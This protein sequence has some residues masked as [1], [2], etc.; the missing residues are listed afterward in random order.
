MD[1]QQNYFAFLGLPESY[2]IDLKALAARSHELQKT[3]HPDRFAHLSEREKRLSVQ[4][5]AYLNEAVTTLKLPLGRAQYLLHLQGIDT[6]SEASVQLEP[7]FLFEQMALRDDLED[8]KV[9]SSPEAALDKF[10]DG[11]AQ[12]LSEYQRAFAECYAVG[13]S[14]SLERAAAVVRKMQFMVKLQK[15]IELVESELD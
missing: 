14:E 3:L 11:V 12:Q 6:I 2:D 1:I 15:E 10:M 9:M 8:I 5:T 4:Y 7:A 13:D